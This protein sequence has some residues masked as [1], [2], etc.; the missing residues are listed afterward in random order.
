M[1]VV[2]SSCGD[3]DDVQNTNLEIFVMPALVFKRAVPIT[4]DFPYGEDSAQKMDIYLPTSN[5]RPAK[6]FIVLHGGGWSSGDKSAM[7]TQVAY[8]RTV[9]PDYAVINLNYRL[10]D[11]KRKGYPMQTDDIGLALQVLDENAEIFNLSK[12]YAMVGISAGGHLAMLYS[13]KFDTAHEVEAVCSIAGPADFSDPVF[14]KYDLFGNG[15]NYLTGFDSYGQ[16]PELFKEV[17]PAFQVTAQSPKTLLLYG[18]SDPIVANT[19]GPIM[20]QKLDEKGVYNELYLYPNAGHANWNT[21]QQNHV[22]L[23]QYAFFRKVF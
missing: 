5:W 4:L 6:A 19:Q 10:A 2:L 20:H 11:G 1:A 12:Q 13:Y 9:F 7:Q 21:D 3:S 23:M 22:N 18:N 15:V 14:Q 8:L 17:S 16:N